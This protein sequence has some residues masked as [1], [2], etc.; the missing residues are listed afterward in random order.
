LTIVV[1][2]FEER[3]LAAK[4]LRLSSGVEDQL[5]HVLQFSLEVVA[6]EIRPLFMDRL[7]NTVASAVVTVLT[8]GV[9]GVLRHSRNCSESSEGGSV[10]VEEMLNPTGA[11]TVLSSALGGVG[12]VG[13]EFELV[14]WH[15][16]VMYF[17]PVVEV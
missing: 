17:G 8:N 2:L 6:D 10:Q 5:R 1:R 4:R 9:N 16:L 13:A 7:A 14:G 15:V 11:V 12:L 3:T